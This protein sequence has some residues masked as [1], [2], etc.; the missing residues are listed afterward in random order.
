MNIQELKGLIKKQNQKWLVV[1]NFEFLY[2]KLGGSEF[3]KI[4]ANTSQK[5]QN[6]IYVDILINSIIDW[7]NVKV[8]DLFEAETDFTS[9]DFKGVNVEE[10]VAFDKE[11][12]DVFLQN[13]IYLVGDLFNGIEKTQISSNQKVEKNKKK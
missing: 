8:K 13:H 1:N 10:V 3:I 2:Q 11:V 12:F 6:D 7:K 4:G 9:E 5:S